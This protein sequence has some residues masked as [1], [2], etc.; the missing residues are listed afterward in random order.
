MIF[1]VS[2]INCIELPIGCT[3]RETLELLDV[4]RDRL[5]TLSFLSQGI[6]RDDIAGLVPSHFA[7]SSGLQ[8]VAR[9]RPPPSKEP[10]CLPG[11]TYSTEAAHLF[12]ATKPPKVILATPKLLTL[13][14]EGRDAAPKYQRR[15]ALFSA[16]QPLHRQ[17]YQWP[18][19]GR[20]SSEPRRKYSFVHSIW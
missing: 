9:Q 17:H 13:G 3:N 14:I 4:G 12:D 15:T 5:Y 20:I 8:G 16:T 19:K 18:N 10:C 1:T 6:K 2:Y 11:F 7:A